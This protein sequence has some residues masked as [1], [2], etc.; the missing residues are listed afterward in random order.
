MGNVIITPHVGG[1]TPEHWERLSEIVTHN[2]R[3]LQ[4]GSD[5]AFRNQVN[6]IVLEP[7][8]STQGVQED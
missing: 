6:D 2:V 3:Q 5:A 8:R 4:K 1:H 7:A